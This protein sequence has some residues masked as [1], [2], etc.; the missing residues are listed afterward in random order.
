MIDKQLY[1]EAYEQHRQWNLLE[2][3]DRLQNI[4]KLSPAQMWR[5]YVELVEFCWRLNPQQS[6]WQRAQKLTALEHYYRRVQQLEA[7]RKIHGKQA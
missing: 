3:A 7:W 2:M 4:D 6:H 5:Q 1:R